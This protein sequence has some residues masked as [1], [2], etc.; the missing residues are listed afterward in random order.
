MPTILTPLATSFRGNY[1]V[2]LISIFHEIPALR[3]LIL[4]PEF[5]N[6]GFSPRWWDTEPISDAEQDLWLM[7]LQRL[8]AFLDGGSGRSFALA[9]CYLRQLP[10]EILKEAEY[11]NPVE[12]LDSCYELLASELASQCPELQ[13]QTSTLFF[14]K[15]SLDELPVPVFILE[16]ESVQG[17]VYESFNTLFWGDDLDTIGETYFKSLGSVLTVTVPAGRRRPFQLDEVFYPQ[18]YSDRFVPLIKFL[19]ERRQNAVQ[20][21]REL[22]KKSA[23]LVAFQGKR[24]GAFLGVAAGYLTQC[25]ETQASEDIQRAEHAVRNK[26]LEYSVKQSQLHAVNDESDITNVNCILRAIQGLDEQDW[27]G[28]ELRLEDFEYVFQ[29]AYYLVGVI[30]G[31]LEVYY[32]LSNEH[33]RFAGMWVHALFHGSEKVDDFAIESVEFRHLQYHFSQEGGT[34][35]VLVYARAD[36]LGEFSGLDRFVLNVG[37]G[38][39]PKGLADFL[40]KD[41]KTLKATIAFKEDVNDLENENA[42]LEIEGETDHAVRNSGLNLGSTE[43]DANTAHG[44]ESLPVEPSLIRASQ[45]ASE[46][47]SDIVS[48][49]V[50]K[51]TDSSLEVLS[52]PQ[53]KSN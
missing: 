18:I 49:T 36:Q 29:E 40:E 30:M 9:S 41:E 10:E 24:I 12:V 6:Y 42:D 46:E 52:D 8:I 51:S 38:S 33:P 14:S 17:L 23:S 4:K 48:A 37:Y 26:K 20:E 22:A 47:L 27:N 50:P 3:Q 39:I 21:S 19:A 11:S 43:W 15:L 16:P 32:R 1:L 44:E 25:G 28:Q 35:G 31:E 53:E 2:Y 5:T 7:E 45:E 34:G 13:K